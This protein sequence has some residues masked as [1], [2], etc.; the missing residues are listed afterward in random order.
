MDAPITLIAGTTTTPCLQPAV[1]PS[2]P[3]GPTDTLDLDELTSASDDEAPVLQPTSSAPWG[4]VTDTDANWKLAISRRQ[5]QRQKKFDQARAE[6]MQAAG[7]ASV[8]PSHTA[9]GAASAENAPAGSKD[10]ACAASARTTQ[11]VKEPRQLR[12]KLPPLPRTDLKIIMRPK[13]GLAIRNFTTHQ[14]SRAVV[15]AGDS[16]QHC[17]GDHFI[18]RTRPGSNIIIAST[19]HVDTAQ[20]LRRITTLTLGGNTHE[21]NTYV[22]APED[23]LR[24]VIHGIDPGTTPEELTANLRVRT[25]GVRV[26]SARMLGATKSAL[27][28]FEGPLIP[29]YVL[30]Y[31]GEVACHPYKPTRQA[32]QV[33]LQPGHRSD[34]CPTPNARV[35][36]QCGTLDPVDGHPCA[37]KCQICGEGHLT[38]AKECSQRLKTLRPRPTPPT[39]PRGRNPQRNPPNRKRRWFSKEGET[40]RSLSHSRSQS[41]PPLPPAGPGQQQQPQNQDRKT[42]GQQQ[43]PTR[44]QPQQASRKSAEK[45]NSTSSAGTDTKVSWPAVGAT[46]IAPPNTQSPAYEHLL[47]ENFKLKQELA[48]VKARQAKDSAQLHALMAR[49]GSPPESTERHSQTNP[50]RQATPKIPPSLPT[51]TDSAVT[52]EEIREMLS[53]LSQQLSQQFSIVFTQHLT[54]F[55]AR[56]DSL[57]TRLD[58]QIA[59]TGGNIRRKRAT[60]S[61]RTTEDQVPLRLSLESLAPELYSTPALTHADLSLTPASQANTPTTTPPHN[62]N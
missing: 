37:P 32:C 51:P 11:H 48:A 14:I 23:T 40:S 9:A 53:A 28:T 45:H 2:E 12:R 58:T 10:A 36:R 26:H 13:K 33:C 60:R 8:P 56:L 49:I 39:Q 31:G 61:S 46:P 41:F 4:P 30:Y 18:I 15:V 43:Q 16:Q 52:R 20:V 50:N 47:A 38:G 17:T 25:Q 6:T 34:V 59:E 21:F 42:K 3:L 35:C 57:E 55:G 62:T 24:G 5:R 22:A 29:R 7:P 27:I 19:P 54:Q 44:Q 1:N